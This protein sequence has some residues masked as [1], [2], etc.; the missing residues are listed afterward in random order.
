MIQVTASVVAFYRY[1]EQAIAK[2]DMKFFEFSLFDKRRC[3][4]LID[5]DC[6]LFAHVIFPPVALFASHRPAGEQ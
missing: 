2:F 3:Q 6:P 5:R 1:I 4:S